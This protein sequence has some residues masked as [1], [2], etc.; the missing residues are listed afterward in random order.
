MFICSHDILTNLAVFETQK[1]HGSTC[2]IQFWEMFQF[3]NPQIHQLE[4]KKWFYR[5]KKSGFYF[6]VESG[7]HNM[8]HLWLQND[9]N[10][11]HKCPDYGQPV[12]INMYDQTMVGL[13]SCSIYYDRV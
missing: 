5:L 4:V 9:P 11:D 7:N 13:E 12:T 1:K 3:A 6:I 8:G 10:L 2:R